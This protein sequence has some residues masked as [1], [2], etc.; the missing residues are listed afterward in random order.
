MCRGDEHR[1]YAEERCRGDVWGNVQ[2][3]LRIAEPEEILLA[4]GDEEEQ[5]RERR[6]RRVY[7]VCYWRT[8]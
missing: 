7:R 2:R 5:D 3:R 6:K 4:Q 8:G 1:R